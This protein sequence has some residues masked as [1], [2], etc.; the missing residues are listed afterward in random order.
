[1]TIFF[2]LMIRRP[3]RSTLFPYT[4][5]FR[6]AGTRSRT[7][8]LPCRLSGRRPADVGR[9]AFG[10]RFVGGPPRLETE[11]L[12]LRKMTLDDAGAVFAYASDPEVTRYVL[13]ETHRSVEDSRAFLDLTERKYEGG[14]EPDWGM[15]YKGDGRFVGTC[16]F[17]GWNREHARAELGYVLN[18]RY[19]GRGLVPE[20]V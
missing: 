13:W 14:G 17:V 3:P 15:A 7:S 18:P 2:F 11:R 1:M 20:A 19:R 4:T 6:S 8:S 10:G 12:V 9:A 5:L 16:G